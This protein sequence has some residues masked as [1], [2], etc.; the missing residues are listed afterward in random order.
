MP[1][2]CRVT[3]PRVES[4]AKA[5][6]KAVARW[7]SMIGRRGLLKG[8]RI[9]SSPPYM[10]SRPRDSCPHRIKC[11][12]AERPN[13]KHKSE[14]VVFLRKFL[15][16]SNGDPSPWPPL[17]WM[18]RGHGARFASWRRGFLFRR[19]I[20]GFGF[21]LGQPGDGAPYLPGFAPHVG[22]Y[23]VLDMAARKA[24]ELRQT[25]AEVNLVP[26]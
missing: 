7:S 12:E 6:T 1:M 26:Q 23:R 20:Q 10:G 9:L 18:E 17:H 25:A 19:S 8:L 22:D 21:R 14:I 3:S 2:T 24:S 11:G 13:L 5:G 15:R 4:G 16:A